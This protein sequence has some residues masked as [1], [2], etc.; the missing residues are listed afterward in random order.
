MCRK[1]V[2]LFCAVALLGVFVTP[3]VAKV[4]PVVYYSFDALTDTIVDESG[5][6][7]DGTPN[8]A[9]QFSETGYLKG[10]FEFNGSDTY[11]EL[12]RPV[13]D[14]FTL[15][16][17]INSDTTGLSG[18][19]A[20]QGNGLFWSDVGGTANDFVVAIL[21][22]N[23]SFFAGNPDTSVISNG[24]V[25]TGEWVHIAAVR[26]TGA[27]TIG[28]F[29]NGAFDNSVDHSNT[30]ALDAQELLAVG[31]NTLDS[32]YYTGLMDEIK[33]YDVALSEAQVQKAM[34]G[35]IKG[36]IA[37]D[38][39]PESGATDV[40]LDAMFSWTAGE[41]AA[42]HD[43]YFGT[44]FDDVNDAGRSN[45]LD[46]LVSQD[47]AEA[48]YEPGLLE[49][50]QTYYWRVDEV[51]AAPDNTIFKGEIWSFTA[52]PI[53]YP[54]ENIVATSNATSQANA[55]PENTVN[56]SGL[57]AD[58][59]HSTMTEDMWAGTTGGA[60]AAW[61]Q[62]EF[63]G[64]YKLY[65]LQVWNYNVAFEALLGFGF[66]DVTIESS[67]N[68][69][70][71]TVLA[72]VQFAQATGKTTYT[73][74]TIV[75]LEGVAAQYVRLTANSA[76]GTSGTVGLSEVRFL[77]TPVLARAPEPADGATNVAVD[78]ALDWRAGRGAT[79]HQVLLGTDA[80]TLA[81]VETVADSTYDPGVLDLDTT[82]YWQI[83]EVSEAEAAGVWE[84]RTWSFATQ[85]YLAV[86]DFEAYNDEDNVIYD[87]WIDGWTNGTG[88]TVGYLTEP[89]AEQTVVHGGNQAMP[90]FY[91]N[92]NSM[93]YAEAELA[94]S[95]G[96]NWTQAGITTL[97]L[98]FYGDLENDAADVYVKIN[99]TKVTGGGSTDMALW[100]QW[101]IDLASTG[102]SLANVTEFVVGVEGT[103]SGVI[104]VDD[105]RLYRGAPAA[106]APADPGTD[107]LALH[108]AFEND[109]TDD[110]GNGYDGTP[111]DTMFYDDAVADLG[112]ALSFDGIDDYV[113]LPIGSLIASLSD[114]TVAMWINLA[115]GT[116]ISWQRAWD[117]GS[118]ST[119][120]YMF[121]APRMNTAGAIRFAISPAG[122]DES[123]VD[124]PEN[125]PADWHHVAATIDS[126]SMTM[127]LYVDGTLAVSGATETLPQDLG[128]TTQNW[129]GRSQYTSD[130]YFK[131]LLADLGIYDR[132]LSAD[133]VNYLAGGR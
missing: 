81:V 84:G 32:R 104:Y 33:I 120:G 71:W 16:A 108:Y 125:L 80:E 83:N 22:T 93:S 103:G 67:E 124:S 130:G 78:T 105:I 70:D 129:L 51:N 114:V 11:V 12:T 20:Y 116:S 4:D 37:T 102:A 115:D 31:A 47:Q 91:D 87:S 95:P 65:E 110:S 69:A 98:Y 44:S 34:R 53:G 106:L 55:G 7:Y 112:R 39:S 96:Q 35:G 133:E 61:I 60:E 76:Y 25:V 27:G 82:Y 18:T 97:T 85:E 66:K 23:F 30:G 77:Y 43:V 38:P 121:L 64:I 1:L 109:I 2:W 79:S 128:T 6:G 56:E 72:D 68:G 28:V 17:W 8:G 62:Y 94:L 63:D 131:G 92:T 117:F 101:N 57:D 21:G 36:E 45:P 74:N 132:A 19:Q 15:A 3:A 5:N 119:G 41:F 73:A 48:G 90:L 13:Q 86:D 100:K 49:F 118:T 54:I 107:N 29:I 52:E 126:A 75:D 9:L 10:C 122:G 40:P 26:D 89:F 111:M 99:G 46:V 59:Q 88:S 24:D 123:L 113:E 42:T 58:D 50:G 127:S 14:D